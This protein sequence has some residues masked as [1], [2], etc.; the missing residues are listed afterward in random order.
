MKTMNKEFYATKQDLSPGL[1]RIE[2]EVIFQYVLRGMFS[3]PTP[4]IYFSVF[5][6]PDLG[7]SRYGNAIG[8]DVFL[9]MEAGTEITVEE[10][11]QRKGGIL[12]DIGLMENPTAFGFQPG[13]QFGDKTII[14]GCVATATGNPTSLARSKWFWRVLSKGFK[15]VHGYYV[16]PEAYK[17]LEQRWRLTSATQSPPEFDLHL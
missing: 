10:V 14:L 3:S 4:T 12:Y 13:G 7:V 5:D 15:N 11:P 6:I 17:L 9:V 2:S 16:G 8:D 1:Q